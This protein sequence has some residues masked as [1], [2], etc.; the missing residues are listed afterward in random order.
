MYAS[1]NRSCL[2][3][4]RRSSPKSKGNKKKKKSDAAIRLFATL[5]CDQ[6]WHS[7]IVVR[8]FYIEKTKCN[9]VRGG[10]RNVA[11][12]LGRK[13]RS[14]VSQ[15]KNARTQQSLYR[16]GKY[17]RYFLRVRF[18][19]EKSSYAR[20]TSMRFVLDSYI[21]RKMLPRSRRS[22]STITLEKSRCPT[23][24]FRCCTVQIQSQWNVSY[25]Y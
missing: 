24:F 23:N 12:K 9:F 18:C 25:I 5:D 20:V 17:R 7:T 2:I 22:F 11:E 6:S 21:A 14:R 8:N 15:E 13:S 19:D 4:L 1:G 16:V 3:A 10:R